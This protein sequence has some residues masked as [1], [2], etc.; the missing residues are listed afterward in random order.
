[1]K[2]FLFLTRVAFILNL[3]FIVCVVLHYNPSTDFLPQSVISLLLIA[4]WGLSLIMNVI[5]NMIFLILLLRGKRKFEL[6]FF[7][8]VNFLLFIFQILYFFF[9]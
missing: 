5:A 8:I 9:T 1:M 7:V 6:F 2:A 4:G 3:V